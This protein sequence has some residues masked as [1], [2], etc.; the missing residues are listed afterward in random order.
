MMEKSKSKALI[1]LQIYPVTLCLKFLYPLEY[2]QVLIISTHLLDVFVQMST[3]W[4]IGLLFLLFLESK[5][6][7]YL[8]C[9]VLAEDKTLREFLQKKKLVSYL[10]LCRI[11]FFHFLGPIFMGNLNILFEHGDMIYGLFI[12][13]SKQINPCECKKIIIFNT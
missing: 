4:L 9:D 6:Q 8:L 7:Y 3:M 5:E 2:L 10:N 12:I 11:Y 1:C 13:I